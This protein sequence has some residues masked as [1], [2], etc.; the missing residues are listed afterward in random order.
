MKTLTLLL[1]IILTA[2]IASCQM[3]TH[4]FYEVRSFDSLLTIKNS[5]AATN[6]TQASQLTTEKARVATRDKTI[7]DLN[8]QLS[9]AKQTIGYRDNT[10]IVLGNNLTAANNKLAKSKVSYDSLLAKGSCQYDADTL[11]VMNADT[12]YWRVEG[13]G[14][15]LKVNK[16]SAIIGIDIIEKN[17]RTYIDKIGTDL[18]L[19]SQ[20]DV[21][22]R[23]DSVMSFTRV[24]QHIDLR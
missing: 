10:I 23:P 12:L 20:S 11:V 19:W 13:N 17:H 6:A 14:I 4:N 24:S 18:K 16:Q 2:T 1:T 3:K 21:E 15:I 9:T 5:L 22:I 7:T 8:G